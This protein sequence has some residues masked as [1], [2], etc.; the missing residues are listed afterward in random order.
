MKFKSMLK[1]NLYPNKVQGNKNYGKIYG[2]VENLPPIDIDGLAQHMSEHNSPYSKGLIKGILQDMVTCVKELML[3]GQPVKLADLAIF[4]AA[5]TSKPA[6]NVEK[7]DLNTHIENVRLCAIATGI[8]SA[9]K[10]TQDGQL[11]YSTMAQKI[12]NGEAVLSLEKGKYLTTDAGG[13][14]DDND[15]PGVVNP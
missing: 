3:N 2:R 4:K 14:G 10:M 6:L 7:F 5:V 13:S 8:M 9:K 1:I 12:K 15:E 11:T